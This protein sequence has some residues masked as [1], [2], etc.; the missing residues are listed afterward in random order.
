MTQIALQAEALRLRRVAQ[1]TAARLILAAVALP[2]LLAA[3]GFFEASLW[4]YLVGQ[5]IAPFAALIMAGANL[6]LAL[7]FLLAA[8]VSRDSRVEIE[9]L[10]VR[11]R[12]L[13]DVRRE[14]TMAAML[15]PATRFVL[16]QLRGSRRK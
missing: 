13:E 11:Q 4:N 14:L 9:A 7:L 10:Q 8:A 1:R 12:A 16:S 15:A 2:F 3:L 6:V 5:F